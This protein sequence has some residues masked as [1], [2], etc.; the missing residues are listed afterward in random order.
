M[1]R[2]SG[3]RPTVTERTYYPPLM[4]V[5]R[6]RGGQSVSEVSYNS[7]PDIQ[8]E[9]LGET[10]LLPV[11]IGQS[12][13]I[14]KS[15]FLQ[16]Q[17]H[18]DESELRHGIMLFLPDEAR[19]VRA[20]ERSLADAIRTMT[21]TC[22]IDTPTIK[23]E[24]RDATFPRI[25]DRLI[26]EVGPQLRKATPQ[27]FPLGFVIALMQLHLEDIMQTIAVSE[28]AILGIITDKKLLTGIGHLNAK[29]SDAVLRFL[30]AYIIVSQI[31]FL[32]L[33][34]SARPKLMEGFSAPAT[35]RKLRTIFKR[36]LEINYKPIFEMDVLDT[37]PTAFLRDTFDLI[38]GLE[39]EHIR[40]E[41]PGRLFHSL[42]PPI[43]RKILAAFYTRPQA[44]E[45][46]ARLAITDAEEAILD[47]ACGSGTIL[48]SAYRHKR[49]LWDSQGF[50]GSPHKRFCENE[51]FG[52]DIMPFA[53]HLASANLAAMEPGITIERTQIVEGDS[54][55]LVPGQRLRS[56][57]QGELFPLARK[58][59]KM[60]G[61]EYQ[62]D[63]QKVDAV[64]MNPPFTKVERRIQDYVDMERFRDLTG[65]EVGLWAHFLFLA[66]EFLADEGVCGAVIPINVLRGRES[67]RTRD[68]L[69]T[70]WTPLYILKP[71]MNCGFS[72]WAD[73][74]DVILVAKK[75]T[76]PPG[77][78]VRF[79][80]IKRDLV[81]LKEEDIHS[82]S[83]RIREMNHLRDEDLDIQDFTVE[84]LR[85]RSMNMMW[86]CGV[87]DYQHREVLLGFIN[88][89]TRNL[90]TFPEGYFRE[91]YRPVPKG[92]SSFL[93]LTRGLGTGRTEEAF[94]GF[95]KEAGRTIRAQ[96]HLGT[97]YDIE[98][99]ALTRSLRTIT[100]LASMDITGEEDYIARQPYGEIERVKRA[101]GF[102]P[103]AGHNW[104]DFWRQLQGELAAVETNLVVVRRINAFSP[105]TSLVSFYSD[106]G[107]SPSN[108]PHVVREP[109]RERAKA[110]C[111][112]F[113]S[114]LF[115]AYFFMLKEE[116]TNR[117]IDVR[118]YDLNEMILYPDDAVVAALARVFDKFSKRRFPALREQFDENFI[119]RYQSHLDM[120]RGN[121]AS[122]FADMTIS[123]S[124]L[125]MDYD[126]AICEALEVDVAD[127]ELH[128]LYRTIVQ[129]MIMI[130]S[131]GVD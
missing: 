34:V 6:Q 99:E 61:E 60:S 62:L 75:G 97:E 114:C 59:K 111:A 120:Q 58:A 42:M 7:F 108:Q 82:I 127:E 77:H 129:E 30:S 10:W 31:L 76:P 131:L 5:I 80:L 109:N 25:L 52:A 70:S 112:L 18:K 14:L 88:K 45:I 15:A 118:A 38:W 126:K 27:A 21:V 91:G 39:V 85:A 110:A 55:R 66:D 2:S 94:L 44:A 54:I 86:F 74:R 83:K 13:E 46:L 65:G 26:N 128:D 96:S 106:H 71:T 100:G 47:P 130:R 35:P 57:L 104:R 125:R 19:R 103:P 9:L 68:F 37:I 3:R 105:N 33:L 1:A 50:A 8:F 90:K 16:Y 72:E 11:K 78:R 79:A 64:L 41:L 93:F 115:F 24:Y 116:S 113:N 73:Y 87:A 98:R 63:L 28:H 117:Y 92:V 67:A 95:D 12:L 43:I 56:G 123:P 40:Y 107:L 84:E 89:F 29:E 32:R 81:Q 121:Q 53:V 48:T 17:R 23:E 49:R 122:L 119:L 22:L 102:H 4:D 124:P 69:F 36:V 20:D 51:I 101:S